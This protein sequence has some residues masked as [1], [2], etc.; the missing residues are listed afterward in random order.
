MKSCICIRTEDEYGWRPRISNDKKLKLFKKYYY[1]R[2][3]QVHKAFFRVFTE[4]KDI[5]DY[6]R[7][8][9][10]VSKHKHYR[11]S[12]WEEDFNDFFVIID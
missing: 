6:P 4:N 10:A 11:V 7:G 1:R 8:I 5:P 3:Y 2:L 9:S 12:M